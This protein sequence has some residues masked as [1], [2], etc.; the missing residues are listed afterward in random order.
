MFIFYLSE[1]GGT[2]DFYVHACSACYKAFNCGDLKEVSCVPIWEHFHALL[3]YMKNFLVTLLTS[4]VKPSRSVHTYLITI[5]RQTRTLV[6]I[7]SH[8]V[9][10]NYLEN[11]TKNCC[12]PSQAVLSFKGW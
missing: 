9:N 3:C 8:R 4:A 1:S 5:M 11:S 6:D 10:S 2:L 7:Y 12:V